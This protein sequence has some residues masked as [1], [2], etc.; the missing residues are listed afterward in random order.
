MSIF[1]Y[2]AAELFNW[3]T[4]KKELLVLDVRNSKD[5]SRF[6]IESPYPFEMK[7]ISYF[8]FMEIEEECVAQLPR[9]K[10]ILIVCAKEGSAKFVAELLDKNGFSDIGYLQGGIKSWGNLLVPM[11]LNPG[12]SYNLYQFVRPGK[13]SCGYGLGYKGELTL[14]D[15]TRAT[16]F[17]LDFAKEHGYTITRCCETHLQ[18][19]YIAGSRLLAENT[20]CDVLANGGDFTGA[21][22]A[23]TPVS[24]N[25][26]LTVAEGSPEVRVM[27]T[28]GHT[29]GSTCFMIDNRFLITG[30][31]VFIKSI[32]RPDLGGKVDEWSDYLFKTLQTVQ[33]LD[34]NLLILP[35]H[36][37]DWQEANENLTLTASLGQ[38]ISH[39][40]S[41]YD[42]DNATDF[43]NFIKANMR[44]QPPEYA[45]IRKVNANLL[46]VDAERAEVLDL[47][48]NECAAEQMAAT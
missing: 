23:W 10:Q 7:N 19:D 15:P 18:A 41:I 43:L 6:Q 39:N 22:F 31:T 16:D 24:D 12:E 48:K 40:K 33:A 1:L 21:Q 29:P 2:T 13:A 4:A 36:Y 38:C 28:P 27:F 46:E 37:M 20:G 25:Q 32:G 11:L 45:E 30:D 47:G 34:H 9:D 3:L 26:L 42:L 5:F 35:G 44:E 8:D 14:F 17:Y